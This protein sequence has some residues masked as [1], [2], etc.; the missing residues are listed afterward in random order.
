MIYQYVTQCGL[1][2]ASAR[3]WYMECDVISHLLELGCIRVCHLSIMMSPVSGQSHRKCC[4]RIALPLAAGSL[5]SM[6]A[7][8]RCGCHVAHVSRA[9]E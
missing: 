6:Q 2:S 5:R 1:G 4:T 8:S 9:R 7:G 3:S